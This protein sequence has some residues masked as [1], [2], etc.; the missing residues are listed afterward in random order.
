MAGVVK[1]VE[2]F[3]ISLADTVGSDTD[4]LTG[5][6][7]IDYC[8]PFVTKRVVTPGTEIE[9]ENHQVD[10]WFT[11]TD[12]LNVQRD[13]SSGAIEVEITVVEFDSTLVN[14]YSDAWQMAD[15]ASTGNYGIGGTVDL[16]KSF[17]VFHSYQNSNV[18]NRYD[19]HMFRGRITST[20]Q[21]T[22]DRG[23]DDINR[24]TADGHFWVIECIG[25]EFSV[26]PI[27]I[28][29]SAVASNTG[30]TSVTKANSLLLGSHYSLDTDG[31][32]NDDNTVDATLT[33]GT[34]VTVQRASSV[35][36]I[37]WSG[38]VVEFADGTAV[39]HGTW[40]EASA[41]GDENF[42]LAT[43]VSFALGTAMLSGSMGSTTAGSFPGTAIADVVDAQCQLTL[44]D[45][46]AGGNFDELRIRHNT[47]GG[48]ASNDISWQV[49]EWGTGVGS[50]PRRVM[51][52]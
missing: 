36:T 48:E 24:G 27:D 6:Q 32:S 45:S 42:T 5:S 14:V 31:E 21:V 10:A 26:D 1:S 22:F 35:G 16:A 44:V 20:T 30:A 47:A 51:V 37:G 2:T 18:L 4:T 7:D 46:D 25:T 15:S 13:V 11:S 29:L 3:I 50:P 9:I 12:T 8:V 40:N 52:R 28:L 23:A 33:N 41:D 43:P 49:I 17:L 39:E 19:S 38:F 34:T